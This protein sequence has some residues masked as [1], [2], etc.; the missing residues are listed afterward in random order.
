MSGPY[1]PPSKMA[2]KSSNLVMCSLILRL[3]MGPHLG[4]YIIPS[5]CLPTGY[6]PLRGL[7]HVELTMLQPPAGCSDAR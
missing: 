5:H 1:L 3:Q 6:L 7:P 2:Y 4:K